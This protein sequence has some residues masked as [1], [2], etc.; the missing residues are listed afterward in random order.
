MTNITKIIQ[1]DVNKPIAYTVG[2][3]AG[4]GADI[5]LMLAQNNDLSGITVITDKELLERRANKLGIAVPNSLLVKHVGISNPSV[6]GQPSTD[7]VSGGL[8]RL[9]TAIYGCMSG[10][11]S[12]MV[13]GP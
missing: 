4:I 10:E 9:D 12:A 3:P 1:R 8:A 7:S 11:F 5:I 2:E 13:T 6:V